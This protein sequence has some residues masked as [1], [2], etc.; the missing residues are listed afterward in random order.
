MFMHPKRQIFTIRT[1]GGESEI[2]L[3]EKRC[4]L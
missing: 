2:E 1:R 3:E 4:Y